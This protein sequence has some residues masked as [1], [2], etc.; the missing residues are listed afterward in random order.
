M[1]EVLFFR[2]TFTFR[3]RLLLIPETKESEVTFVARQGKARQMVWVG[4]SRSA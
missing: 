3:L 1:V 4:R 2:F